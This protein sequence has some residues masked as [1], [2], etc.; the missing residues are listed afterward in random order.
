MPRPRLAFLGLGWI[1]RHRL[2]AIAATGRAEIV[3]LA[4]V[5]PVSVDA[6]AA[7][8]PAAA[9]GRSLDDLLAHAP[10]GVVIATPSARHAREA[11]VALEAGSAVFCQKPLARSASE[12][13]AVVEAARACDR[14]LA[15]DLSYRHLDATRRVT[16]LVANGTLGRLH[17]VDL[18]FHNAYGPG[19]PWYFRKAESG[20]GCLLDLGIH[21]LDLLALWVA[22]PFTVTAAALSTKG[23][24]WA[25][26]TSDVEDFALVQLQSAGGIA[27]RVACSWGTPSGCD[28]IIE[29]RLFGT[30]A[31]ARIAN[32]SGSFYDFTAER[33]D[34]SGAATL[35]RPPD[36]WGG[37]AAVAWV[38]ALA[39]SPRFD[40]A[41]ERLVELSALIDGCYEAA[42]SGGARQCT[43]LEG[44]DGAGASSTSRSRMARARRNASRIRA[45]DGFAP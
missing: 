15:V 13:A 37:R 4:D 44:T 7:I 9:R 24:P 40:P 36:D 22:E 10:D 5:D 35:A 38:D 32:V 41:A 1:G 33:L 17:A 29:A 26:S 39:A 3:A 34:G 31:G 16:E 42:C 6:A 28:A 23:R 20:G 30:A 12:A 19:Q 27:A 8:A 25:E 45:D 11:V 21:L 43:P 18:A 14:R 2:Q